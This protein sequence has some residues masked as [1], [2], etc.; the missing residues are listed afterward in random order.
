M[1]L[2]K[3]ATPTHM[4][5]IPLQPT[6]PVVSLP[7]EIVETNVVD[8]ELV[9]AISEESS[10]FSVSGLSI[11]SSRHSWPHENRGTDVDLEPPWVE[12]SNSTAD[13][14]TIAACFS[15]FRWGLGTNACI[16]IGSAFSEPVRQC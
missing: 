8:A 7:S 4:R 3:P 11:A 16:T 13:E 12:P 10:N 1:G 5:Q 15:G 9:R 14:I 2:M 6:P